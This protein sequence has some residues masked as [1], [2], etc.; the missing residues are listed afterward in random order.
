MTVGLA[1][2]GLAFDSSVS[3]FRHCD[4]LVGHRRG[5]YDVAGR[6]DHRAWNW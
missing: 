4:Y 1:N 6:A 3:F 2:Q 5:L